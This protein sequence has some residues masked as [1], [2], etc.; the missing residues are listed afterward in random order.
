MH[1]DLLETYIDLIKQASSDFPLLDLACGSGRNGLYL[2]EQEVPVVFADIKED[3]LTQVQQSLELLNNRT[4]LN[5]SASCTWQ[6][7]FEKENTQPL[8]DKSYGGIIVYRYLH[9]PLMAAIKQAIMAGGFI[10]YETFTEQQA[11]FGRPKNPNFLLKSK[12]LN[13]CFEGWHIH[14]SFEGVVTSPLTGNKQAIAQIVA[15]KP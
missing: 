12:E 5:K 14:H 6:V 8:K 1:S 3:T 7:D 10:I 13:A 2:A 9:R 4:V 11:E 15:Q